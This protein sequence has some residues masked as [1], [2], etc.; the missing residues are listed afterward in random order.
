MKEIRIG[1]VS[2]LCIALLLPLIN[3]NLEENYASPID[4]RMLTE[5]NLSGGDI[6]DMVESYI[7]DR[8]GFRTEAI[9]AYTE[10]ND[11]VFGMM[12]HPTY[13]YGK[14]GYVFFQMSYENPDPVF[15]ELFCAYL[16]RVQDY[17]EER[18]VPFIYC[19][20]PSKITIYQQYLPAGYIYQDK[21]N[22]MMYE[23]LE[24]YGVNQVPLRP[25]VEK[26]LAEQWIRGAQKD[27]PQSKSI[28]SDSMP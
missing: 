27:M 3:F 5:W 14:D 17:C 22:Q 26:H 8:I 28:S 10:L 7:N 11:K 6:T 2:I 15:V 4:N 25:T 9:D 12:V 19:L 23:K 21:L 24:E 16:R 18:G 20:N 13:T 1:F